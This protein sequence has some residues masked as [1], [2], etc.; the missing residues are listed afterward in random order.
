MAIETP[1][2]ESEQRTRTNLYITYDWLF[3]D[4]KIVITTLEQ[5]EG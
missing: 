5:C 1:T 4:H 3:A 2:H